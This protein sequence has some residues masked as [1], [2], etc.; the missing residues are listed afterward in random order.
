MEKRSVSQELYA[1]RLLAHGKISAAQ[2]EAG[3]SLKTQEPFS[4]CVVP[5]EATTSTLIL[6]DLMLLHDD[7]SSDFPCPLG[8]WT[9]GAIKKIAPDA[10]NLADYDVYWASGFE[11]QPL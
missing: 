5:K 7:E 11:S 1:G 3:F 2:M 6:V 10:I 9:P 8:D 4:I